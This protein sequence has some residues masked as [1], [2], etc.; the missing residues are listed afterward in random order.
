MHDPRV[1]RLTVL[2]TVDAQLCRGPTIDHTPGEGCCEIM[3]ST[4]H[5][6]M[7]LACTHYRRTLQCIRSV[8]K[9]Y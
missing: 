3:E 1:H 6:G 9:S 7:N 2:K 8:M 4:P 5:N